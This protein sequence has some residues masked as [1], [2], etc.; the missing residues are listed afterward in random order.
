MRSPGMMLT[1]CAHASVDSPWSGVAS[2]TDVIHLSTL[3][4][5]RTFPRPGA[6]PKAPTRSCALPRAH[7]RRADARDPH[8]ERR[9]TL[10]SAAHPHGYLGNEPLTDD[11]AARIL[12][13]L[14]RRYHLGEPCVRL[15]M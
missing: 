12:D 13:A 4:H 7:P 9:R 2:P 14:R 3:I 11:A 1:A 6:G 15:R 5:H 8:G 10:P